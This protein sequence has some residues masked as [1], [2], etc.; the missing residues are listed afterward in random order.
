MSEDSSAGGDPTDAGNDLRGDSTVDEAEEWDFGLGETQT[1]D[2]TGDR[3]STEVE[4]LRDHLADISDGAGC[5]EIWD[6]LSE[7]RSGEE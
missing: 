7:K 3:G 5:T 4:R 2:G 1:G 6:H